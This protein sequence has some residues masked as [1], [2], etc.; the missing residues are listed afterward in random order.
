MRSSSSI[1][2]FISANSCR[3]RSLSRRVQAH[4]SQCH[5]LPALTMVGL[6]EVLRSLCVLLL[7][8]HY[9]CRLF[10][11][12]NATLPRPFL[13]IAVSGQPYCLMTEG[14]SLEATP[15]DIALRI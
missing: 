1:S 11:K 13:A 15:G 6:D 3:R 10:G 2:R 4:G 9:L 12:A 5:S 14:L 7:I 8:R